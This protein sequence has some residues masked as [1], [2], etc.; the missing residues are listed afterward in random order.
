MKIDLGRVF[1]AALRQS[2]SDILI[3]TD[4]PPVLRINGELIPLKTEALTEEDTKEMVYDILSNDEIARFEADKEL[5]FAIATREGHRFRGNV[6]LQRGCVGASFRLILDQIP[7]FDELGVPEIIKD[8]CLKPKGLVLLTGPTG[9]GKSTTQAAMIDYI[10]THRKCHIVTIEDPVEFIHTNKKS[11]IE[12]REVKFDT[13]SFPEALTHVLRQ[14]PDVIL[15]GEIRDLESI[16]TALTAAETGHL[17]ITTLHTNDAVQSIDRILDVFHPQQQGQ[18]KTQLSFALIAVIA[19]I[20]IPRADG[21]GRVLAS[22][23]LINTPA[24][25]NM[26]RERK[27]QQI[28]T[29]IET[30]ARLGM[31]TMD[32]SI[33]ELYIKGIISHEDA[34]SH[35]TSPGVLDNL[36]G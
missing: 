22:E 35:V 27:N 18:I 3:T 11:Y 14:D 34:L 8:I 4:A 28:K 23:V 33:K 13:K 24:V 5:D 20:L 6:F 12:Q 19:Q 29:I 2:A 9:H 36:N 32:S 17:V 16:A 21:E 31:Q 15:V 1:D 26:I 25:A 30:Q 7:N 10:N